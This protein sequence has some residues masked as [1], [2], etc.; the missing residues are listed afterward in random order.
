MQKS[1]SFSAARSEGTSLIS[2]GREERGGIFPS[3]RSQ[4]GHFLRPCKERKHFKTFPRSASVVLSGVLH[5]SAV[6]ISPWLLWADGA[7]SSSIGVLNGPGIKE[8]T[9]KG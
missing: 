7:E 5:R 6:S 9:A 4:F 3:G 1:P 8:E 2:F